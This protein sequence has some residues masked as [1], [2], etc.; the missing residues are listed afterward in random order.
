MMY[1]TGMKTEVIEILF[2]TVIKE[3]KN[4]F[5]KKDSGYTF[6]GVEGVRDEG[7]VRIK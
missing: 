4:R 7:I 3:M 2:A 5:D 1:E 6:T